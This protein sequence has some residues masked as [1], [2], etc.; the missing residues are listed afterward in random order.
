MPVV[1]LPHLAITLQPTKVCTL[2]L[3]TLKLP[4]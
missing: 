4:C 2:Y 3:S 1:L